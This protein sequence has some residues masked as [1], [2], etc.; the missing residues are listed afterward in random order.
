[1]SPTV[2]PASGHTDHGIQP[3]DTSGMEGEC[4]RGTVSSALISS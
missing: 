1:M 3:G 2:V 4:A